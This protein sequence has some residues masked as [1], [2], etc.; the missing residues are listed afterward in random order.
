[1][2]KI[3]LQTFHHIVF[4]TGAGM[5]AESGVAT[6]RGAGGRWKEYNWQEVACQRAFDRDPE[7]VLDFHRLRRREAIGCEPHAGHKVIAG[8][9][10]AHPGVTVVT[11]N[12]DGMHQRAGT[13]KIF[14][15]HGSLWRVRCP[16]HGVWEDRDPEFATRRCPHCGSWLRPDIIWFEDMLDD[17]VVAG[18]TRAILACDLL[19]SIGTSA[20]VWPAAGYPELAR[21]N[22]AF[23]VEINPEPT[24]ISGL[25]QQVIRGKA[26]EVL[27]ELFEK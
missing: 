6:F 7:R 17:K 27:P 3:D 8:L 22:G 15:L 10:A 12:I 14:E 18:A 11:Q 20:V 25:Y 5:S 23:C 1:M 9:E 24:E 2:E 26:G 4:F 16:Q 21:Q 19:I 13:K